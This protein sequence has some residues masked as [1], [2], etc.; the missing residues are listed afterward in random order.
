VSHGIKKAG[1]RPPRYDPPKPP[2]YN[3]HKEIDAALDQ[4][5]RSWS[6]W[7]GAFAGEIK[8]ATLDYETREGERR[9]HDALV[10][11]EA[12]GSQTH[13]AAWAVANQLSL[14]YPWEKDDQRDR[15]D[16]TQPPPPPFGKGR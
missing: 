6:E 2:K 1:A 9:F 13:E 12:W 8:R 5:S 10:Y 15:T 3:D 4:W 14:A 16:A 7:L 11:L